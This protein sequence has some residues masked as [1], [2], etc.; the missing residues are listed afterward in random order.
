MSTYS[1]PLRTLMV[2]VLALL[3][4]AA[5]ATGTTTVLRTPQEKRSF[6]AVRIV[7]MNDTVDVDPEVG[8]Y[9]ERQL[10][11]YLYGKAQFKPGEDLTLQIRFI[12]LDKGSRAARYMFGFGAGK[13]TMTIEGV[14]LDADGNELSRIQV[15]GEISAGFFGGDFK[16]AVNQA[17]KEM[18]EYTVANFQ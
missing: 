10:K 5:C 14:Y 2:C 12:Q 15:G 8:A 13:G 7:R 17:A 6:E 3:L 16:E 1:S 18:G 11:D 4:L 9:F